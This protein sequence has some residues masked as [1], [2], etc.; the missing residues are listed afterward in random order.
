MANKIAVQ[1][2]LQH[3]Y[4]TF[5]S[6][7]STVRRGFSS[8][9]HLQRRARR[10][11]AWLLGEL[12]VGDGPGAQLGDIR[13]R[14]LREPP[15]VTRPSVDKVHVRQR[16]QPSTIKTRFTNVSGALKAAVRDSV[17]GRA[18]TSKVKRPR[19][20]KAEAAMT[21]PTTGEVGRLIGAADA[22][23]AVF[24]AVCAFA[25]LRLGEAAAMQ[26]GDVDFFSGRSVWRARCSTSAATRSRSAPQ[27]TAASA[28]C[29]CRT[30]CSSSWPST[31]ATRC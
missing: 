21:I 10:K 16:V 23:S 3:G 28:P 13:K 8:P 11:F 6:Q 9:P 30:V 26:V 14:A 7:T 12:A 5:E 18:V 24:V 15:H 19:L 20:R 29:R 1:L 17:L 31:C 27:S 2:W 25:G 4:R 22:R